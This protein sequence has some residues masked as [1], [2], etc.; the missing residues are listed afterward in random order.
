MPD[1]EGCGFGVSRRRWHRVAGSRRRSLAALSAAR[2]VDR[3]TVALALAQGSVQRRFP[4]DFGGASGTGRTGPVGQHQ[5]GLSASAIPRPQTDCRDGDERWSRRDPSARRHVCFAARS[6][7]S[8][9]T[10]SVS[11]PEAGAN[12]LALTAGPNR[13]PEPR[14]EIIQGGAKS[15]TGSGTKS[16][17]PDHCAPNFQ[18]RLWKL[19]HDPQLFFLTYPPKP[20]MCSPDPRPAAA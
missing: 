8:G 19:P 20:P 3:G 10:A 2:Q 12:P 11:P 14:P 18:P 6:V 7:G 5:P 16:K 1:D 4:S 17:P 15:A 9:R 13:P